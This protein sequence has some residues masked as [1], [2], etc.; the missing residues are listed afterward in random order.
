MAGCDTVYQ[1]TIGADIIVGA[2]IQ[3]S[4]VSCS[5]LDD[6]EALITGLTDNVNAGPYDIE[7]YDSTGMLVSSVNGLSN[8]LQTGLAAG[9]Y[10]TVLTDG[11]CFSDTIRFTVNESDPIE[12]TILDVGDQ[13]CI[14][15][16]P[17]GF[18]EVI[19]SGG[20]VNPGSDY[21]YSWNGGL[22]NGAFIDQLSSGLYILTVTDD[23]LC[24]ETETVIVSQAQSPSI[25][26]IV[27][28]NV[29]CLGDSTAILTVFFTEGS[30]P[31]TSINWST[32]DTS[33]TITGLAPGTYN[34]TIRDSLFCFDLGMFTIDAPIDVVVDSLILDHPLCPGEDNG[35]ITVH[36][37]GGVMPYTYIWS[38]GDTSDF[39]L[40][41]GL[42]AG[43]YSV[44]IIDAEN[45]G[46]ADTTITLVDPPS[47][48]FSFSGI[49]SVSCP[50]TCDGIVTLLPS[51]GSPGLP[52][53][54][55][56]ESGFTE[57]GI[58]S[59]AN[60]LCQGFQSVTI[61]QNNICFFEDSVFIPSP[62]P[63]T[64]T[65][66]MD[67]A[68]CF[69]VEDGA[70]SIVP[71]GGTPQYMINWNTGDDAFLLD[72]LAA[73]RYDFT[74]TDSKACMFT[75]SA[76]VLQPDSFILSFDTLSSRPISCG[77]SND[78]LLSFEV[79]GGNSGVNQFTWDPD[80]S[81]TFLAA[82]LGPGIYHVTATDSKGCQDTA[83]TQLFAPTP[84][85]PFFGDIE[86]PPCFGDETLIQ[87]DSASGGNGGFFWSINNGERLPLGV[88]IPVPSG[89]YTI[90]VFDSTGCNVDT[91]HI[92]EDPPPIV[93]TVL[94]E[95]PQLTLGDSL[96]LNI[97]VDSLQHP[98]ETIAW[99][100]V[101]DLSCI[102]CPS[103]FVHPVIPT[104]YT[105][106][107]ID[108]AGCLGQ[109]EI[110]VEVNSNR[111][112]YIPNVFSP[113][114]DGRNDIFRIT[115]GQGVINI[116]S[117]SIFNRWGEVVFFQENI[118]PFSNVG[119][120]GKYKE[121][122]LDPAVFVYLIE[123]QFLDNEVLLYRGD[124]TL[125]R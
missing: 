75:N 48:T 116:K 58:S 4:P 12:I 107:V 73:G 100:P 101:S 47:S 68:S 74:I 61:T 51:G 104:L 35:Q 69:S 109:Q 108:S 70:L 124:V 93:V 22:L 86:D 44:T 27:A 16:D 23:N 14:I 11:L 85:M 21:V 114:D 113:N 123:V 79:T 82:N 115:T 64:A 54:Y 38:S 80:V 43:D 25:D 78:G 76:L 57:S 42:G 117:M 71:E 8:Y 119:W 15:S 94:P 98:I 13:G 18:I 19:A 33:A 5:G 102:N 49:D 89:I 26:S 6:G 46:M 7:V 118:S 45:C 112:I 105:V 2:D 55:F 60:D 121:E 125:V 97:V 99:N 1:F 3:T 87:I 31:V 122:S 56:W 32:G 83:S 67:S 120:D 66:Q 95:T 52:Y 59:T 110:F 50:Q 77:G 91:L 37:S 17:D 10:S 106:T 39:N 81:Q 111:Q 28:S 103:P 34:V 63:I 96:Q 62:P 9:N 92:I 24:T 20:S 88:S 40:L 90:T 36:A 65:V 53:V 84:I 29:S 72:Q 30:S 41:P